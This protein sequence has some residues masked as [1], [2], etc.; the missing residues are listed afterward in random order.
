MP[1]DCQDDDDYCN[2]YYH[3]SSNYN[4]RIKVS[5][6]FKPVSYVALRVAQKISLLIQLI[7]PMYS[8]TDFT[9]NELAV[10]RLL[11]CA[12][13]NADPACVVRQ[14]QDF[15]IATAIVAMEYMERFIMQ[16][17]FDLTT[18]PSALFF[19]HLLCACFLL[20]IKQLDDYMPC[21]VRWS[22]LNHLEV[23][24]TIHFEFL[25]CITLD[26]K[27]VVF[28]HAF[29]VQYKSVMY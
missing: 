2:K 11:L 17:G 16:F 6:P 13:T 9:I 1:Q 4:K 10:E 19:Q 21:T 23:K 8:V 5:K 18:P 26:W 20:A 24:E 14:E 27:L 28:E 15:A 3:C 22:K 7:L 25:V 12:L 29:D